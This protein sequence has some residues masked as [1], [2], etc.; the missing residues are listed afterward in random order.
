MK[1][2]LL[3]GARFHGFYLAQLLVS[4]GHDLFILNRGLARS[5]YPFPAHLLVADRNDQKQLEQVL[6]GHA[7]DCVIDN[8]GYTGEQ[9]AALLKVIN[10][11]AAHYIFVSSTA[12]YQKLTSD[13]PI[14]E[15]EGF[16]PVKGFFSKKIL[17][18]AVGKAAAEVEVMKSECPWTIIRFPN[19]FGEGDFAGK[20]SYF[21]SRFAS[22][23]PLLLEAEVKSFSLIYVHD[24]VSIIASSV[25]NQ[26]LFGA[27]FHA[28]A[29]KVY[30]YDVFF[31]EVFGALYNPDF[32]VKHPAAKICEAAFNLP[33]AWGPPLNL[34]KG[35]ELLGR[36]PCTSL[37]DWGQRAVAWEL[38]HDFGGMPPSCITS[39]GDLEL[40]A[41]GM[42]S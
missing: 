36:F 19:I 27:S 32:L 7:F 37:A 23:R 39:P 4:E 25:A 9:I 12:V 13:E 20:L 35:E 29:Q 1:I 24:A 34:R 42:L 5:S 14:D 28:A 33:F 2:L 17:P 26:T 18:Y 8:N 30:S 11:R 16:S 6:A 22:R 40:A 15:N 38:G 3:G 31:S 21:H 41:I 10:C